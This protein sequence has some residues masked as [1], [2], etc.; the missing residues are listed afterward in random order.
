MTTKEF[1]IRD[2]VKEDVPGLLA[3][4]EVMFN[5]SRMSYFGPFHYE[6]C[7]ALFYATLNMEEDTKGHTIGIGII[8]EDF[9]A[10]ENEDGEVEFV[11]APVAMFLGQLQPAWFGDYHETIEYFFYVCPTV[12]KSGIGRAVMDE[13]I[14]QAR[15][16]GGD[17][18][19]PI[20]IQSTAYRDPKEISKFYESMGFSYAGGYYCLTDR[21]EGELEVL[22]DEDF[23]L[24]E[25]S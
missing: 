2:M 3:L 18:L 23:R 22:P 25:N 16:K 19:G 21:F 14:R 24:K 8:A 15:E 11:W 17:Q 5:E 4:G 9:N 1:R 7:M 12:R 6:R 13:Y 20:Y 10:V